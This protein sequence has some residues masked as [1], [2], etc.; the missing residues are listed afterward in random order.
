MELID[1]TVHPERFISG[2]IPGMFQFFGGTGYGY[3]ASHGSDDR[4]RT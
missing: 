3:L 4:G 2:N 1:E